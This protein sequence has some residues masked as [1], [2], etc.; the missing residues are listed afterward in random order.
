M[1]VEKFISSLF[2]V[3]D[4]VN[5]WP[6]TLAEHWEKEKEAKIKYWCI[7]FFHIQIQAIF[8]SYNTKSYNSL[9]SR[10]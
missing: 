4:F 7:I 10:E 3:L 2:V 8:S 6:L 5:L 9:G 1:S